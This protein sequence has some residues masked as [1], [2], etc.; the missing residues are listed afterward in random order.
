MSNLKIWQTLAQKETSIIESLKLARDSYDSEI[1]NL[2]SRIENIDKIIKEYIYGIKNIDVE[3]SFLLYKN[4]VDMINK[5]TDAKKGLREVQSNYQNKMNNISKIIGRQKIELYK[6]EKLHENSL[7]V[8]S[9]EQEKGLNNEFE[10]IALRGY[11]I[12]KF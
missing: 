2:N 6:Y 9:A 11:M 12:D 3:P 4:R 8:Q 7:K 5:L 1:K 10:E